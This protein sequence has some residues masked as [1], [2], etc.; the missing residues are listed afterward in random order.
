MPVGGMPLHS[1]TAPRAGTE[2]HRAHA[3]SRTMVSHPVEP[4]ADI[5]NVLSLRQQPNPV[6]LLN[7]FAQQMGLQQY[8][9]VCRVADAHDRKL[10]LWYVAVH[11]RGPKLPRGS[12][13]TWATAPRK[14]QAK[15]A[16]ALVQ[17]S[18]LKRDFSGGRDSLPGMQQRRHGTSVTDATAMLR[19]AATSAPA[20]ALVP[21][22]ASSSSWRRVAAAATT[23]TTTTAP[24]G[25]AVTP[26]PTS[27][28]AT[29]Q[30]PR[31]DTAAPSAA[32]ASRRL[33]PDA[34]VFTPKS[35]A[36]LVD[37]DRRGQVMP[38]ALLPQA[39]PHIVQHWPAAPAMPH[40]MA[41][42]DVWDE[43][44]AAGQVEPYMRVMAYFG[45]RGCRT[46]HVLVPELNELAAK[47]GAALWVDHVCEWIPRMPGSSSM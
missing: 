14:A 33:S 36:A 44:H 7:N 37:C 6:L 11:V 27:T 12:R 40:Y 5:Q 26:A 42:D 23:T 30:A 38:P 17:L 25:D 2:E 21:A 28:P 19:V 32:P 4:L 9:R 16:A 29:S 31:S 1:S 8:Y 34:A 41:A 45:L 39:P 46:P 13:E 35:G 3:P 10:L 20:P 43:W 15:Q 22:P 18:H 24:V 47:V